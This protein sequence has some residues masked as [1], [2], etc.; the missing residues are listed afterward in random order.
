MRDDE[1][2]AFRKEWPRSLL[3]ARLKIATKQRAN[4]ASQV[5]VFKD[6]V[7]DPKP[8]CFLGVGRGVLTLWSRRAKP[9]ERSEGCRS[10]L[11]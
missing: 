11:V 7:V 6:F 4:L 10:S 9:A 8:W 3:R 2:Y 1:T 5:L